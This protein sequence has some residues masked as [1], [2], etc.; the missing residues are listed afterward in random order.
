M[1]EFCCPAC[2]SP[3]ATV[4]GHLGNRV[5]VRCRDCGIDYSAD[6]DDEG[7]PLDDEDD[8][9]PDEAQEWHDFDPDC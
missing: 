2:E 1:H 9:Q 8:G 4:L 5:H 7:E 6:V 3:N